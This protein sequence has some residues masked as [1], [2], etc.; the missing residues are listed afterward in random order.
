MVNKLNGFLIL[1][2]LIILIIFM[3]RLFKKTEGYKIIFSEVFWII[4]PWTVCLVLY[5]ISGIKYE[6]NLNFF[7]LGYIIL[8]LVLFLL[9]RFLAYK[10]KIK[11]E[12]NINEESNEKKNEI[13]EYSFSKKM[14]LLPLFIM[15]CVAC[16]IYTIYMINTNNIVIGVTRNVKTDGFTTTMLFFSSCSLIIWL[17]ELA[18]SILNEKNIT[19]YGIFSAIIYNLPVFLISGRDALMIF[20]ISTLIIFIYCRNFRKKVMKQESKISKKYLKISIIAIII[21][22][23]YLLVVSNN[24][25]GNNNDSIIDMFKFAS[26]AEFPEY[27]IKI[28]NSGSLGR[29]FVN[30]VFYYTSQFSKFSLIFQN[31]NGPYLLG[32]YQ[33]Q[34]ISRHLPLDSPL[35]YYLVTSQISQITTNA[36]ISGMS[37]LWETAIGYLIYDYGRIGTL[38]FALFLGYIIGKISKNVKKNINILNIILQTMICVAM[39]T[40]V[41]LSAIFDYF[42]IFPLA[43]FI[44]INIIL[45]VEGIHERKKE[46]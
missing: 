45:K 33:M 9:G 41:E 23:L 25:Y 6:Y 36:G 40:T 15:S 14:N 3:I 28:N 34:I 42:Y 29:L 13:I 16:I 21:I 46:K 2:F 4:V 39:F 26:G 22:L 10:M 8:F 1:C 17:Y 24:R 35:N 27:L 37:V 44:L 7:S 43:W 18:Y 19:I 11:P 32:F 12:K 20:L 38:I 31:Y 30:F 5:F